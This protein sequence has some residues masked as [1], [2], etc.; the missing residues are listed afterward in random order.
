MMFSRIP[1]MILM[2]SLIGARSEA[3]E[4]ET[5]VEDLMVDLVDLTVDPMVDQVSL[6]PELLLL[7]MVEL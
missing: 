1:G 4:N 3:L 7:L 6:S 5:L 2:R